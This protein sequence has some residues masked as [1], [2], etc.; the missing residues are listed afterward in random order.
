MN[1]YFSV[2]IP[3]YNKARYIERTINSVLDQSFTDFEIIVVDDGSTD[4]GPEK[5]EAFGD[6]RIRLIRQENA[7][8]SSAR[9]R[10][11]R[12]ATGRFIAFLDA[13]DEWL[14]GKLAAHWDFSTRYPD[15]RWSVSGFVRRGP[16]G[17]VETGAAVTRVFD[18]ALLAMSEG[19]V[20]WTGAVV[21]SRE[22]FQPDCL[23]PI[24]IS[25][26]EDREVWLKLA[27]RYPV[28]GYVGR[29]LAIYN[30]DIPASLTSTASAE[31]DFSFFHLADRLSAFTA[32]L[33][34]PR[35]QMFEQYLTNF[36]RRACLSFTVTNRGFFR[37]VKEE[38]LRKYLTRSQFICLR[39]I[40]RWP[41]PVKKVLSRLMYAAGFF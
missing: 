11:I 37:C 7:G 13:D 18:D 34:G 9:N 1:P 38:T 32:A 24:G 28:V 6:P 39:L 16:R 10:G 30:A 41:L 17:D 14:E 5:V 21:I 23:F 40:C 12:E 33:S 15:C 35:R 20:V 8:V 31:V 3:L 4:R 2:V 22:C 26:S 19:L 27:C 29:S 25:R 36:N